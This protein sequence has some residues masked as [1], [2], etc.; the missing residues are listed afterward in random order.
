MSVCLTTISFVEHIRPQ[1]MYSWTVN[2]LA[3]YCHE[4]FK[5]FFYVCEYLSS[6]H[7]ITKLY[8]L[9]Q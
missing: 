8:D 1:N 4:A 6:V 7:L 3:Q 5:N 2:I 9:H